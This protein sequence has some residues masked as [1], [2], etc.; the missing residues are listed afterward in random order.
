MNYYGLGLPII[1]M[2][3]E[4]VWNKEDTLYNKRWFQKEHQESNVIRI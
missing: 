1:Q 3:K 2:I 4:Q